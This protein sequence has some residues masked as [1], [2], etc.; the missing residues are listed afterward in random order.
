[1]FIKGRKRG[2]KRVLARSYTDSRAGPPPTGPS[3]EGLLV[4][5]ELLISLSAFPA[6]GNSFSRS[7]RLSLLPRKCHWYLQTPRHLL[8]HSPGGGGGGGAGS[9]LVCDVNNKRRAKTAFIPTP[10]LEGLSFRY[11]IR[12]LSVV[13]QD[14]GLELKESL[15]WGPQGIGRTEPSKASVQ[16]GG[17]ILEKSVKQDLG[18]WGPE[19]RKDLLGLTH[20]QE[21]ARI[22]GRVGL[23]TGRRDRL[24][25][26][27]RRLGVS[28]WGKVMQL[29]SLF[30]GQQPHPRHVRSMGGEWEA[31]KGVS[32][33]WWLCTVSDLLHFLPAL[34]IHR[35][36][37]VLF[38]APTLGVGRDL[39]L[40]VTLF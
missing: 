14:P 29:Q 2:K 25:M 15:E 38:T 31:I 39:E 35:V 18:N 37:S 9:P 22:R 5:W 21:Q 24:R 17:W 33:S 32:Q 12:L 11:Q 8:F 23:F 10:L 34:G 7:D 36:A 16:R 13:W 20:C 4:T 30:M 6:L 40:G 28:H 19:S 3:L 1:M 27:R 26:E